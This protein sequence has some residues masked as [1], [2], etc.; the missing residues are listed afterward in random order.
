MQF[1]SP[2]T[3]NKR[4]WR[5]HDRRTRVDRDG[6]NGC[7]DRCVDQTAGAIRIARQRACGGI[8]ELPRH[9]QRHI[10]R[11]WRV[12]RP[13]ILVKDE[14]EALRARFH[15]PTL[16][17]V[18]LE[19]PLELQRL[20]PRPKPVDRAYRCPRLSTRPPSSSTERSVVLTQSTLGRCRRTDV[21]RPT[22]LIQYTEY[23]IIVRST[24]TG[25]QKWST[26]V[27]FSL[28]ARTRPSQRHHTNRL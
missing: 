7:I 19:R 28:M 20:S 15:A 8:V 18:I 21:V 24:Q 9:R 5:T 3:S 13:S 14:A 4:R 23:L 1:A 27:T 22:R 17:R 16:L 2:S 26:I 12:R 11:R 10:R 25:G 6:V